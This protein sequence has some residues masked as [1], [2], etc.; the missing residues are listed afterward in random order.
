M[1]SLPYEVSIGNFTGLSTNVDSFIAELRYNISTNY[2]PVYSNLFVETSA[3]SGLF[4]CTSAFTAGRNDLKVGVMP[5]G[6]TLPGACV[7]TVERIRG[8]A[9]L[10]G[11]SD[12][13]LTFM[14]A[15]YALEE[16]DG[17]FYPQGGSPR[18][19]VVVPD[20]SDPSAALIITYGLTTDYLL[21]YS[22]ADWKLESMLNWKT[23]QVY[24]TKVAMIRVDLNGDYNR[25]GNPINHVKESEAVEFSGPKGM[26][27]LVNGNDDD[28]DA[29][30]DYKDSVVNGV[31]DLADIYTLKIA[32]LGIA[33]ESIPWNMTLELSVTNPLAEPSGTPNAKDRVRI[34]RSKS[35]SAQGVIG[36]DPL[37]DKVVFKKNPGCSDMD[38]RL[39]SGTGDLEI[40]IEGIEYGREV[41]VMLAAKLNGQ[42]FCADSIRLFASPF[43]A[44]ANTDM[45]T[46]AY[47]SNGWQGSFYDST[48]NAL[49]GVVTVVKYD[50]DFTQDFAEIG[51]TRSAPGQ[52]V[53]KLCTIVGFKGTRYA[54]Q[55]ASDTGYF[56]IEAGNPGGNVEASPPIQGYPYGRLIVGSSLKPN[57]RSFLQAQKVQTDNGN[58]IV[59]PV[60]WLRV[61]HVDEVM[62]IIPVG[63]GYKVLVADLDLAIYMLRNCPNYKTDGEFMTREQLLAS[64]D[65]PLNAERIAEINGNLALIRTTLSK[66]LGIK[67]SELIRVPVAFNVDGGGGPRDTYLPNMI[68]M[69]VVKNASGIRRLV[70]PDPFFEP[71]AD[72]L[73]AELESNG[74][75]TGEAW[76]INTSGPHGDGGEAHCASNVRREMP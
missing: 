11:N 2:Q 13:T 66:G 8:P 58:M 23:R 33:A 70:V 10:L 71:F 63:S 62:T 35:P 39:L 57:I 15:E 59:L 61:Q 76:F 53:R 9:D 27:I 45:A 54:D 43:I 29:E 3:T 64:Y 32:K 51:A 38:I 60:D 67:V 5:L 75:Q 24:V 30:P 46:K 14:G 19:V 40:G 31:N 72:Q 26:V 28:G 17:W 41:I 48:T 16:E 68:N 74:Y 37:P 49:N 56:H 73:V 1:T 42:I 6:G 18:D 44:L 36:P 50:G 22:M 25:D 47:V 7:P 21:R 69:I 20:P 4:R 12:C 34:F 52:A 55:V 65:H